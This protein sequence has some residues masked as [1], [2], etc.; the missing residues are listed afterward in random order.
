M[1]TLLPAVLLFV[2]V[3]GVAGERS[4]TK[5]VAPYML[6]RGIAGHSMFTVRS[7]DLPGVGLRDPILTSVQWNTTW[8]PSSQ[9]EKATI[10]YWR[11]GSVQDLGCK[12]IAPNSSGITFDY[13]AERFA[14]GATIIIRHKADYAKTIS[15]P[16]GR[17]TV[18]FNYRY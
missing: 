6:T 3:A 12:E 2:S 9:N 4:V 11:P 8:F 16:A 1:R 18:T 15:N 17:D 10:C 7:T 5:S 14:T 13:N